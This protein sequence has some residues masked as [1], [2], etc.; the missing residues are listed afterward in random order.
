[1]T[2]EAIADLVGKIK[3]KGRTALAIVCTGEE[4]DRRISQIMLYLTGNSELVV[5]R[6]KERSAVKGQREEG[7]KQE[8]VGRPNKRGSNNSPCSS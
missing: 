2:Y 8:Q 1:M 4:V 7:K 6:Y 3:S 5:T